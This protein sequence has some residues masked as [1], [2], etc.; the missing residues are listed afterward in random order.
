MSMETQYLKTLVY[1]L[2]GYIKN[3]ENVEK[4]IVTHS[5]AAAGS[6]LASGWMT[7]TG[8]AIATGL[9]FG[10]VIS[11]YYGICKEC[12]I[13]IGKNVLRALASVVVAET[14]AYLGVILAAEL[15]LSF[16]PVVG[17]LSASFLAGIV[18]FGMVYVAGAL[19]VKMMVNVF[20]AKGEI[21]NMTEEE[22]KNAM[23]DVSTR[24]NIKAAYDESK[25]VYKQAKNDD[26][27]NADDIKPAE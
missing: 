14:A 18:N 10:F 7:G 11:M 5:L 22:L 12:N 23:K 9:A 13:S 19:F 24:D 20:K 26:S 3:A 25:D 21:G 6:A 2:K 16:I 27:Y 15:V 17:N 1:G 4:I 8:G